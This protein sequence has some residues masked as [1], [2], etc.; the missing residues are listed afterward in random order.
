MSERNLSRLIDVESMV[1]EFQSRHAAAA[2]H[3]DREQLH[4]QR[5]LAAAAP[6][7]DA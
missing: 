7:R 4:E 6:A 2:S 5:R 3:Q 1:G